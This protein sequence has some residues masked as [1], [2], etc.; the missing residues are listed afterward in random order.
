MN[1]MCD[2][3]DRNKT[4]GEIIAEYGMTDEQVKFYQQYSMERSCYKYEK[5]AAEKIG[6]SELVK[7]WKYN[8]YYDAGYRGADHCSN[9]HS[10]RYVHIAKNTQT[11]EVIKF[12]IK[13]V[14]DFFQIT[15]IQLKFIKQGFNEANKEIMNAIDKFVIYKG[16]FDKYE[17]KFHYAEKLNKVLEYNASMFAFSYDAFENLLKIGEVKQIIQLKLFLPRDFEWRIDSA[18]KKMQREIR[19]QEILAQKANQL[20]DNQQVFDYVKNNHPSAFTILD[21]LHKKVCLNA[22]TE[23]Q[24]QLYDK[25][26]ATK[27]KAIDAIIKDVDNKKFTVKNNYIFI[28]EDLVDKYQRYGMSP[29]QFDL[30]NKCITE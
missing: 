16:D 11:G 23:K 17:S 25:L 24:Q 14:S 27:W 4:F 13:C 18:Y 28:Y 26:L 20:N 5:T 3:K 29:K 6:S 12:G 21:S 22:A 1:T 9:G 30:L 2:K 10:L 8:G 7:D 15:P 19:E